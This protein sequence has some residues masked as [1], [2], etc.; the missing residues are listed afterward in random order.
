M[1]Y[2]TNILEQ[3]KNFVQKRGAKEP[4]K[5]IMDIFRR[6]LINRHISVI[7]LRLIRKM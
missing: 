2:K 4:E 3:N 7:I 6:L 1:L 5:A